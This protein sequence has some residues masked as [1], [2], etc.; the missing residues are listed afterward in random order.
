MMQI[1]QQQKEGARGIETMHWNWWIWLE[2]S[3]REW[4]EH[5]WSDH[6]WW[7]P[8]RLQRPENNYTCDQKVATK[9]KDDCKGDPRNIDMHRV[10][11]RERAG[12]FRIACTHK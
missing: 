10:E 6:D 1:V 12:V 11:A 4:S 5:D 3:D 2:L 8:R 9:A 7:M